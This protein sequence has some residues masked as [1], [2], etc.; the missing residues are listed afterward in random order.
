MY[1]HEGLFIVAGLVVGPL[2][3]IACVRGMLSREGMYDR[4]STNMMLI[5]QSVGVVIGVLM[6]LYGLRRITLLMF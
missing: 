5:G 6:F 2:L 3:A 1:R 4:E